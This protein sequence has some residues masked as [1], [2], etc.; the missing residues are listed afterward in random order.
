MP[1]ELDAWLEQSSEEALDPSLPICD[2]HH[3]LWDKPGD[4]Y[5]ID[6]VTSDMGSGHNV[7][8]SLFVEVDSMYRASGPPEMR[9]VGEVEWAR[10]IGAQS[11]SGLYGPTK[12]SAGIVGYADLNLER[13][14]GQFWKRWSWPVAVGSAA[15]GTPAVGTPTN[16]F[17]LT[18]PA[19]LG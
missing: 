8:Q 12:V 7:V 1:A 6:E 11:D 14:L 5:M 13:L 18:A 17:D 2:P 19:G 15:Y 3:H 4:R 10:G 9:P 16:H